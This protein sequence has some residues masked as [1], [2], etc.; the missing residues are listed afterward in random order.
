MLIAHCR[1]SAA[2]VGRPDPLGMKPELRPVHWEDPLQLS[3][4]SGFL[5][6]NWPR[7]T[8]PVQGRMKI[9]CH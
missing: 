3:W 7:L 6:Y 2:K 9:L 4:P 5:V 8:E 1:G